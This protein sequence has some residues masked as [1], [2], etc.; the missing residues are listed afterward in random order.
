MNK[1]E[2]LKLQEQDNSFTENL[3]VVGMLLVI[4]HFPFGMCQVSSFRNCTRPLEDHL[5]YPGFSPSV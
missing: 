5:Q 2:N 4:K 1:S 3:H